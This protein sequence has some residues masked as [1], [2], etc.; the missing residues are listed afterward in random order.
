MLPAASRAQARILHRSPSCTYEVQT[1]LARTL[2]CPST[3][4]LVSG[5]AFPLRENRKVRLC[6]D[7]LCNIHNLHKNACSL[8]EP[9][10]GGMLL[11]NRDCSIH[12]SCFSPVLFS[13][14]TLQ[15]P[16]ITAATF[17]FPGTETSTA[18]HGLDGQQMTPGKDMSPSKA[19]LAHAAQATLVLKGHP[20]GHRDMDHLQALRRVKLRLPAPLA[21]RE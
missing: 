7:L 14:I 21:S 8:D 5:I 10:M 4:R 6:K 12:P 1:V 20:Q 13:A 18:P 2:R 11:H 3:C 16:T 15:N 19:P 9:C 17:I